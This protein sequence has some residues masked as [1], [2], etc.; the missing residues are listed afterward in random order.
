MSR[1]PVYTYT[2]CWIICEKVREK[3]M[4]IKLI[5]WGPHKIIW[6]P[7]LGSRPQLWEPLTYRRDSLWLW[8]GQLQ[9]Y[10]PDWSGQ[11][12]QPQTYH[13]FRLIEY[14][15]YLGIHSTAPLN[16]SARGLSLSEV[17][18]LSQRASATSGRTRAHSG[19]PQYAL[20]FQS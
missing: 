18:K 17:L 12:C 9:F 15:R 19:T 20:H 7:H 6:G 8:G 1:H 10:N 16:H 13:H 4:D 14:C 5:I 2:R 11:R 3:E